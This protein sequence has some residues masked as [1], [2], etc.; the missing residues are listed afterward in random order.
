MNRLMRIAFPVLAASI[1][2]FPSSAS[3]AGKTK[4][5][6][7]ATVKSVAPTTLTVTADGKDTSF[8]V[9]AKTSVIGK[10]IGTKTDAKGGKAAITDLLAAG[11]RVSVVYL[12]PAATPRAT[13]VELTAKASAR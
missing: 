12:G 1:L 6:A 7:S 8:S 10:G 4:L 2:A 9:D 13:R 11:D 3:A 5:L